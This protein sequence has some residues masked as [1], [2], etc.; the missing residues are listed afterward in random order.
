VD[1]GHE[2]ENQQLRGRWLVKMFGGPAIVDGQ[3]AKGFIAIRPALAATSEEAA[4]IGKASLVSELRAL[5][6]EFDHEELR[7]V[8]CWRLE[9]G[10]KKPEEYTT[11]FLTEGVC[12]EE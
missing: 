8:N 5:G 4:E 2:E 3:A 6:T 7:V 1:V 11:H 10:A 12:R 9:D